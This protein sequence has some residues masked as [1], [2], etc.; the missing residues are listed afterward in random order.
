MPGQSQPFKLKISFCD[1][2][3]PKIAFG[4]SQHVALG[5]AH[6]PTGAVRPATL[7]VSVEW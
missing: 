3:R 1:Y 4:S 6:D 7:I 2:R 5:V